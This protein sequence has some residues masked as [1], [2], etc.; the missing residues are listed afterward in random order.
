VEDPIR[1]DLTRAELGELGLK[2]FVD[3][4][5]TARRLLESMPR[6][7]RAA[8]AAAAAERLLREDESLPASE[9]RAYL[10]TWRPVLDTVWSGLAGDEEASRGVCRAVAHY[11]LTPEYHERQHENPADADGNAIMAVFYSA[12]CFLHGCLEFSGWAG[13]RAFDAAA[14]RAASDKDWPHR[15][16][17]DVSPYS[18]ELAHPAVQSELDRQM[19]DLEILDEAGEVPPVE[20]LRN[21]VERS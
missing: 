20:Q 5:T 10:T 7:V 2:Y 11:Y 3:V 6:P 15:R 18:W 19:E 12:E 8:F 4:R 16:P 1:G 21:P 14:V 13:W 17:P 9:H